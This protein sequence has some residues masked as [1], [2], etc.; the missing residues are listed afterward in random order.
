[1][2]PNTH[3]FLISSS[4]KV[5]VSSAK[6]CRFRQVLLWH[7]RLERN[8]G[9]YLPSPSMDLGRVAATTL[10][11]LAQR[12]PATRAATRGN[13]PE[14]AAL[15]GELVG[16]DD[17][18]ARGVA[19]RVVDERGAA[20]A[21]EKWAHH[22]GARN[23]APA[24]KV[25]LECLGCRT[26]LKRARVGRSAAQGY[27]RGRERAKKGPRKGQERAKKGPRAEMGRG[28]G[29]D[30]AEKG[31]RKGQERAAKGPRKGQERARKGPRKGRERVRKGTRKGQERDEK[32]PGKGRER[33]RTG[34]L[35]GA[36]YR[37]HVHRPCI[38]SVPA[39]R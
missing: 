12:R 39:R 18:G 1:M 23:V 22:V 24:G 31:L 19:R 6:W 5:H 4:V 13:A 21:G 7:G 37:A 38:G 30:G 2:L 3:P 36:R 15:D 16:G 27:E 29:R 20:L 33:A 32:G 10:C 28:K 25:L 17:S 26:H 14:D 8:D 35:R 34:Q 9:Q 11:A